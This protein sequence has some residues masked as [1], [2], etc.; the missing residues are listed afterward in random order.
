MKEI[1]LSQ[2]EY[3]SFSPILFEEGQHSKFRCFFVNQKGFLLK[4]FQGKEE[5]I[6]RKKEQIHNLLQVSSIEGSA[7]PIALFSVE[8]KKFGYLCPFFYGSS[9]FQ[10]II[11]HSQPTYSFLEKK[12]AIEMTTTQLKKFHQKGIVLNDIRLSN[13]LIEKNGG[14]FIDF[15]DSILEDSSSFPPSLYHFYSIENSKII[16]NKPSFNEDRRKEALCA[17]SLFFHIDFDFLFYSYG[18]EA[19]E[20]LLSCVEKESIYS[21]MIKEICF[22]SSVPYFDSY[23]PFFQEERKVNKTAKKIAVKIKRNYP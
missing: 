5:E 2:E 10:F 7:Y 15:E 22:S 1:S 6:P 13:H 8:E 20:F 19:Q 4:E 21:E 12:K 11:N 17:L 18:S 23:L 16:P 3:D 9:S 14:H